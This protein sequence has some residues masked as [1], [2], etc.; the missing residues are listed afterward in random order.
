MHTYKEEACDNLLY[1]INEK[2]NKY[3]AEVIVKYCSGHFSGNEIVTAKNCLIENFEEQVNEI[4][5]NLMS[6]LKQGR[7][8]SVHRSAH[9]AT[10]TDICNVLTRLDSNNA[11][12]KIGPIDNSVITTVNP[13]ALSETAMITRFKDIENRLL[14]I[15]REN[16]E[17]KAI[18]SADKAMISKLEADIKDLQN[19]NINL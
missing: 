8:N 14:N 7:R 3:H 15:E 5:P 19:I 9:E 4:D 16:T 6:D 10:L 11:R 18:C 12:I 13:D 17:L 2:I 1:Y